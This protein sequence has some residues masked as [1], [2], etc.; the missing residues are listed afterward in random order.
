MKDG[1]ASVCCESPERSEEEQTAGA[2]HV[3]DVDDVDRG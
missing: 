1:K 3:D 2:D